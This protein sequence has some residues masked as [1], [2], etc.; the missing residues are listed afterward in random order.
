MAQEQSPIYA[1]L[2]YTVLAELE[3]SIAEY[4]FLDMVQKLHIHQ[5]WCTKS[6]QHCADDMRISKRGLIKMRDR[7]IERGLIEKNAK[8]GLR[9]TTKYTDVAVNKVHHQQ[10]EVVNKVPKSVNKVHRSGELSATKNNNRI[11]KELGSGYK[12]AKAMRDEL[13]KRKSLA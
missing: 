6:L 4:F 10:S 7:L 8:G 12:K 2:M 9:V 13:A 11:T 5:H 1:T 3:I